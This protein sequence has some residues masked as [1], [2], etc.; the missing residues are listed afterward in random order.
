MYPI[1]LTTLLLNRG[2]GLPGGID[3]P[4]GVAKLA[5][6]ADDTERSYT[7]IGAVD[8]SRRD[9]FIADVELDSIF[10][11]NSRG[12]FKSESFGR[13]LTQGMMRRPSGLAFFDKVL[14]V[15]DHEQGLV[16]RFRLSSDVPR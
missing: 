1:L 12:V 8:P 5:K 3:D 13:S 10:K 2:F 15:L 16:L 6:R 9:I 14:Y 11:Y 4:D 7:T